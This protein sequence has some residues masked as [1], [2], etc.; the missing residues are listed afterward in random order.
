ML[1]SYKIHVRRIIDADTIE[2]DIDLG[3]GIVMTGQ[4]IRLFGINAPERG[5][6]AGKEAKEALQVLVSKSKQFT[7]HTI[8]DKKGKYGRW[9][10]TL[11]ADGMDVNHWLVK[12]D[13]AE[14][15][16]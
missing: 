7:L 6:E 10:G 3:F 9:L 15:W 1:Y 5:T 13:Y 11:T 14:I 12:H 8:K 16:E 2:V 4:K